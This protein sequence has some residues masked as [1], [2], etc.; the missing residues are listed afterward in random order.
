MAAS[1]S[2]VQQGNQWSLLRRLVMRGGKQ[3]KCRAGERRAGVTL[4]LVMVIVPTVVPGRL[5]PD[6]AATSVKCRAKEFSKLHAG[7]LFLFA[8]L[9]KAFYC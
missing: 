1:L 3:C 7:F 5:P 6:R 4:L 9:V 8:T 2:P